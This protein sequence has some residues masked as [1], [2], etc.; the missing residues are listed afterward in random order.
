[1]AGF[2]PTQPVIINKTLG[3]T[4]V[5]T[6]QVLPNSIVDLIIRLRDTTKIVKLAFT[7]LQSGTNYFTLDVNHP[8]LRFEDIFAS[9]LTIY[10]QGTTDSVV[11]EIMALR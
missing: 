10:A 2:R 1:M 9:N 6:S 3:L 5:E 7:A 8:S 11:L 4:G